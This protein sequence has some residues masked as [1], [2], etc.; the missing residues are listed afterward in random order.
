MPDPL[1]PML[2]RKSTRK[3][4]AN[5]PCAGC[6]ACC[7][8]DLVML[9]PEMGDRP[10]TYETF[11]A[12]NPLTGERGLALKHKPTGGCYYLGEKGCMIHG[13]APAVCRTFD[14]RQ[15]YKDLFSIPRPDRRRLMRK[16]RSEGLLSDDVMKA[17][18]DRLHTLK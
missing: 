18:R 11:M 10:E 1:I 14:C 4:V 6:T 12:T 9:H 17:G 15:L 8:A 5:V 2:H 13:R 3:L 16:V 7:K